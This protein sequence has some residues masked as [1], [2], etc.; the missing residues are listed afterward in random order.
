[1]NG[2]SLF[3]A[4]VL[5][6][7]KATHVLIFVLLNL[8]LWAF[9]FFL[10]RPT[11]IDMYEM[12][13]NPLF[14]AI[15]SL[16]DF[17]PDS[18]YLASPFRR[19]SFVVLL[20][21]LL[22]LHFRGYHFIY[23]PIHILKRW[24]ESQKRKSSILFILFWTVLILIPVGSVLY[25][26]RNHSIIIPYMDTWVS[27]D[28]IDKYFS[29]KLTFSHLWEW[30]G[31]GFHRNL[32]PRVVE[33]LAADAV[34]WQFIYI[35]TVT[36]FFAIAVFFL[37]VIRLISNREN[38][39][40]LLTFLT[41]PLI[42]A[43]IF[44]MRLT[45][46]WTWD[47]GIVSFFCI[48]PVV[49][50]FF[51]LTTKATLSWKRIFAVFCL[52]VVSNSSFTA[53]VAFWP[54]SF[55]VILFS[56]NDIAEKRKMATFWLVASSLFLKVYFIDYG[57]GNPDAMSLFSFLS[58]KE[59]FLKYFMVYL[60]G[61][62]IPDPSGFI[63]GMILGFAGC[64][65]FS[66]SL[67]RRL[68]NPNISDNQTRFF[69]ALGMFSFFAG[70]FIAIGRYR[71]GLSGALSFNYLNFSNLFFISLLG[72]TILEVR[73]IKVK[74]KTEYLF[75]LIVVLLVLYIHFISFL[76]YEHVKTESRIIN[77]CKNQLLRGEKLTEFYE[78]FQA[79]QLLKGKLKIL[80][81]R[82]LNIFYTDQT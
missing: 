40:T 26:I 57:I 2:K 42:S 25:L 62:M 71:G 66:I 82:K 64:V 61:T 36:F 38:L 44:S 7:L 33:I 56:D 76:S 59:L 18:F 41:I 10:F 60:S 3:S 80:K 75:A 39:F 4:F 73:R 52:G 74:P 51:L 58:E 79:P 65:Y 50:A 28:Y 19:F 70:L 9:H 11:S 35:N 63:L 43:V 21:N 67:L 13:S 6:K 34:H 47:Q 54:A 69:L 8:F 30:H 16:R 77:Q 20:A 53:G 72:L 49:A 22:A 31:G 46:T 29:G 81:K 27:V 1:M 15:F 37:I 14:N 24:I 78:V 32:F 23:F 17:F 55:V 45:K 5:K 12:R 48:L 68:V